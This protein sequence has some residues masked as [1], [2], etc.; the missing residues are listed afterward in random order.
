MRQIRKKYVEDFGKNA[1]KLSCASPKATREIAED[2]G[3]YENLLYNWRR[4][5][6]TDV[7]KTKHATLEGENRALLRELTEIRMEC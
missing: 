4:K 2:L 5:H 7:D 1:V 6:T 3:I